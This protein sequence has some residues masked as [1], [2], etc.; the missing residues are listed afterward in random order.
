MRLTLPQYLACSMSFQSTHPRGVRQM[1]GMQTRQSSCF[2]PRTHAGCDPLRANPHPSLPCFNP[3]TH[4]GCD[5][6]AQKY[7]FLTGVSIHAPTR[8]ATPCF[9]SHRNPSTRFNPRTHA[10][11][12][13]SCLLS[14]SCVLLFQSTHPRG[15][16]QEDS[17][18]S[19]SSL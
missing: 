11:C 6:E 4:A 9:H 16:R 14:C 8:G 15:V 19:I 18:I 2:N 13:G 7:I 1:H 17:Y 3:R 12:D 5:T 10:G